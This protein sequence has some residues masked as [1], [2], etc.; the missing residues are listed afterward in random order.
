MRFING[1]FKFPTTGGGADF[2]S[3]MRPM[4]PKINAMPGVLYFELAARDGDPDVILAVEAFDDDAAHARMWVTDEFKLV[5]AALDRL[6]PSSRF[7][8]HHVDAVVTDFWG[9]DHPSVGS[10]RLPPQRVNTGAET[11]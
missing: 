7:D 11:R 9:T 2:L 4:I 5:R 1:W 3:V 8:V 10:N 6:N